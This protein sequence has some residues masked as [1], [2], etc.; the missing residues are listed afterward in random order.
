MDVKKKILI[1]GIGNLLLKDEGIGIHVVERLKSMSLPSDVEVIDGGTLSSSFL[2]LIEGR[3]KVIV[4]NSMKGNGPP[5]TIYRFTDEDIEDKR[6]GYY[7]TIQEL[8][9]MDAFRQSRFM[10]TQPDKVIFIGI[11]P[12]DTGEKNLM[13][14]TSLS[15]TIEKKI[16]IIIEM[17]ME[18]IEKSNPKFY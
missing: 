17:V 14:E 15:P 3:K 10:G 11:E 16:P 9:F 4:L 7:R 6:K 12:E 8:E 1:L 13:L 5:G 2:Y 18:E